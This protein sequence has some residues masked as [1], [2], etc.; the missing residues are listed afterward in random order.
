MANG[1]GKQKRIQLIIT[2]TDKATQRI[3][4]INKKIAN[5]FPARLQK[6]GARL[7]EAIGFP[8]LGKSFG[9]VGSD[10]GNVFG[11]VFRLSKWLVGLGVAGLFTT[12]KLSRGFAEL[13]DRTSDAA[14]RLG[15]TTRMYQQLQGMA[16][17]EGVAPEALDSALDKFNKNIGEAAHGAGEALP[18]L[19]ALGI[20]VKDKL[21]GRVRPLGE[22]LRDVVEEL[23]HFKNASVRAMFGTRI[24][25]KGYKEIDELVAG[26]KANFAALSAEVER[27]GGVLSEDGVRRGAELQ[28]QMGRLDVAFQGAKNTILSA[29]APALSSLFGG[30]ANYIADN[31]VWIEIMATDFAQR[32]PAAFEK[33]AAFGER[34]LNRLAPLGRL[35]TWLGD[36]FGYAETIGTGLAIFFGG[37]L[38]LS[39]GKLIFDLIGLG[40]TLTWV[41]LRLAV[42]FM[43]TLLTDLQI[44]FALIRGGQP[45]L[46]SLG[47][48]LPTLIAPF[49]A[50]TAAAL[51]F[52]QALLFSPVTWILAA[53]VAVY[54]LWKNWDSVCEAIN[55]ATTA[56]RRFFGLDTYQLSPDVGERKLAGMDNRFLAGQTGQGLG[57]ADAFTQNYSSTKTETRE[58]QLKVMFENAPRGT[59]VQQSGS[60]LP[61]DF[62]LGY[63]GVY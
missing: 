29:L 38:A 6:S 34:M 28:E 18:A 46:S 27:L 5:S 37:K 59:R 11:E 47:L 12:F 52:G 33:A 61:M 7:S 21:T 14:Q 39:I 36:R 2:A 57:A 55:R 15:V 24:F 35:F 19:D 53:A 8:E 1:D 3:R 54:L 60:P 9:R 4:E 16:K 25:G 51:T 32:L 58:S 10:I 13:G 49:K 40:K 50:V 45:V 26:G 20:S 30:L 44:A 17:I 63:G 23:S 48:L 42:L 62:S 43:P 56:V 41:G 31:R 22:M